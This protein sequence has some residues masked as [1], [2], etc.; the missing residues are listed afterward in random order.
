MEKNMKENVYICIMNHF[1]IDQ[2]L[3]Q[4]CKSILIQKNKLKKIEV[5]GNLCPLSLL[6]LM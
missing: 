5:T 4:H 1:A 2:K 6:F 3:P